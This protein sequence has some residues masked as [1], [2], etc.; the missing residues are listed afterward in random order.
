MPVHNRQ[1]AGIIPS[2]TSMPNPMGTAP[3]WWVKKNSKILITLPGPPRE[4]MEMWNSQV[5]ER[6]RPLITGTVIRTR[7]FK[8]IGLG[9]ASVDEMVKHL[10]G[11]NE[12]DLG[13]Y[14]K[15][16]GIYL[17]AIVKSNDEKI[18]LSRLDGID[19]DI[20]EALGSYIWGIDEDRPEEQLGRLLA[21]SGYTLAV[22]ESCTG[23][24]IASAITEVPGSSNY[25]LGGVVS[26]SNDAKAFTGVDPS[27]IKKHGAVS[28]ECA[29]AMAEAVRD[30][31]GA[32]CAI[33]TTG[34]AGPEEIDGNPGGTVFIGYAHPKG[35]GVIKHQF[36][37]RRPLVRHRAVTQALLEL[38]QALQ[39]A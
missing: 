15:P 32:D 12:L 4:L 18:A 8:T 11:Q 22:M 6:M 27:I 30:T 21:D 25:F 17:R 38:V 20:R 3:G 24:M 7:T 16:D 34:I 31:F 2:A 29:G 36:P 9:E 10:Y 35:S 5:V 1:Q 26:Y 37:P 23:G 13:C 19:K 28:L 39:R 33:S 14:A